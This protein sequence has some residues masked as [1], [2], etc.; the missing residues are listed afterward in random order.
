MAQEQQ[1]QIAELLD[2]P[3]TYLNPQTEVVVIVDDSASIDQDVFNLEEFEGAEWVLVSDQVPIDESRR[4]QLLEQFQ[5]TG[6][7]QPEPG[8]SVE[9]ADTEDLE[10]TET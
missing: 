10:D 5:A 3:G 2:R 6:S 4:D 7:A 1:Y 9:A 8:Q